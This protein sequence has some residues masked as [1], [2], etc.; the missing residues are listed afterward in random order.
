MLSYPN[1]RQFIFIDFILWKGYC[2]ASSIL[3]TFFFRVSL[4]LECYP[5]IFK[6]VDMR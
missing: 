3:E 2:R 6:N 1:A 4:F 5:L